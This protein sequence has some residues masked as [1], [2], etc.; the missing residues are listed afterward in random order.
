[1]VSLLSLSTVWPRLKAGCSLQ[2]HFAT[3]HALQ[4]GFC[5]PGMLLKASEYLD[6][7]SDPDP[8]RIRQQL[9]GNLC[10]CTGY[11]NIVGAISLAAKGEDSDKSE[12][13]NLCTHSGR[14]EDSRLLRG[15][16]TLLTISSCLVNFMRASSVP[17]WRMRR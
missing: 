15:E 7:N 4:C 12:S 2:S 14:V 1:M 16:G 6:Q 17:K 13:R 10:R 8:A 3:Q 5:T 11:Q 9:R